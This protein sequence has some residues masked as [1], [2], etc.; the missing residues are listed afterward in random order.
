M[1]FCLLLF[2]LESRNLCID[3]ESVDSVPFA[4]VCFVIL[5]LKAPSGVLAGKLRGQV[6]GKRSGCGAAELFDVL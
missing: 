1:G 5:L 4:C 6:E 2:F 3:C